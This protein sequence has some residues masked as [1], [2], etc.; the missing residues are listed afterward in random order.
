MFGPK[1][2]G[3]LH[4]GVISMPIYGERYQEGRRQILIYSLWEWTWTEIFEN[5]F[6]EI[7]TD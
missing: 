5:C 1:Q 4:T 2:I 7:Y 3:I 6:V